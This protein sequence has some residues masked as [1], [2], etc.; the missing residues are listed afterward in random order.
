MS[1]VNKKPLLTLVS[2][3]SLNS[4]M[5]GNYSIEVLGLKSTNLPCVI[6]SS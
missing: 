4:P 1:I 5:V 2:N 6:I 3:F